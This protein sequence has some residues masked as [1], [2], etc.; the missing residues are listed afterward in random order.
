MSNWW[1][2][3]IPI[4]TSLVGLFGIAAGL[5]GNLF[6]RIP[7]LLR[8]VLIAGGLALMI[9]ESITDIIGIAIIVAV[10]VIQYGVARKNRVDKPKETDA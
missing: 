6:E 2:I 3:I 9:P 7:M 10:F 8:I 4:I 1:E 5:N